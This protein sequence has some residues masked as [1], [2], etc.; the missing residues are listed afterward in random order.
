V[1]REKGFEPS[2]S[3]LARLHSTTELLPQQAVGLWT[4]L[5]AALRGGVKQGARRISPESFEG[6]AE[7]A[8]RGKA[9]AAFGSTA[10]AGVGGDVSVTT[11]PMD[12][13]ASSSAPRWLGALLLSL[14]LALVT[15]CGGGPG[16]K[17]MVDSPITQFE[18]PDE[19]EIEGDEDDDE[20]EAPAAAGDQE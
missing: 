6:V 20:D 2:T 3:T 12:L 10:G 1:E 16:G 14:A 17:L 9:A 11:A 7:R 15:G 8:G 13:N 18:A 5:V 4:E 19:D